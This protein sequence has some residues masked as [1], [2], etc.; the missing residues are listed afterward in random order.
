M[1]EHIEL[2]LYREVE[3]KIGFKKE[4]N[5]Y[6]VS[7]IIFR[8]RGSSILTTGSLGRNLLMA[9]YWCSTSLKATNPISIP[10]SA[11]FFSFFPSFSKE[12][13]IV[14]CKD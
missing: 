14:V 5:L 9:G 2:R 7:I 4:L 8:T 13:S 12:P 6:H 3:R 10:A 1:G 11:R